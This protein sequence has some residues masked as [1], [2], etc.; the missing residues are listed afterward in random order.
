[1]MDISCHRHGIA[2]EKFTVLNGFSEALV[3]Y[4][5]QEEKVLND[6]EKK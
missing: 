3:D 5:V 6:G 4:V 1:M 2:Y